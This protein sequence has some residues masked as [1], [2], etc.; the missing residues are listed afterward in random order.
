VRHLIFIGVIH[1]MVSWVMTPY[2][3]LEG[4]HPEDGGSMAL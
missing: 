1:V 2:S 4:Y 3:D